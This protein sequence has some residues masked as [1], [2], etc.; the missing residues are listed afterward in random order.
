MPLDVLKPTPESDDF[1]SPHGRGKSNFHLGAFADEA[2]FGPIRSEHAMS[3]FAVERQP[4]RFG[5]ALHTKTGQPWRR[6]QLRYAMELD[7]GVQH[8]AVVA[9]DHGQR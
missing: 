5:D 2:N 6:P 1:G 3:R 7:V 8:A 4:N 9:V